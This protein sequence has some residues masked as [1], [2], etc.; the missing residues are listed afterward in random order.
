MAKMFLETV[1]FGVR[2][3]EAGEFEGRKYG[4]STRIYVEEGFGEDRKDVL[5]SCFV[6]YKVGDG[7]EFERFTKFA[8]PCRVKLEMESQADGKGGSRL[9]VKTVVPLDPLPAPTQ[10]KAA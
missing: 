4:S 3:T 1:L 10:K 2:K 5:G 8:F 6:A 9:I 7:S